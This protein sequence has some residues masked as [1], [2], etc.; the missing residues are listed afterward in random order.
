M[1][2]ADRAYHITGYKDEKGQGTVHGPTASR[3]VEFET[4]LLLEARAE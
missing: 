2:V 1:G 4:H 3:D